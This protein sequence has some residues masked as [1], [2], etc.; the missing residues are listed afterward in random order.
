MV[1]RLLAPTTFGTLPFESDRVYIFGAGPMQPPVSSLAV[2]VLCFASILTD[3]FVCSAQVFSL[4]ASGASFANAS[5]LDA[6]QASAMDQNI[7]LIDTQAR[8]PLESQAGSLSKLDLKAPGKARHEY[9][10]GYQLLLRKDMTGALEHLT[11][12]TSIYPSFVAAHNAL[13]SAYLGLNRNEDARGE[14]ERSI[15]LDDHLPNSYFYLGCAELALKDY[16]SAEKSIQKATTIAPLDLELL[17]ALAYGQYMNGDFAAAVSTANRVHERK[18]AGASM[19]HLYAAAALE[20][21]RDYTGAQNQ[22]NIM[23]KEDPKSPAAEQ[24]HQL[25]ARL[26]EEALHPPS[27]DDGLNITITTIPAAAPTGPVLMP[28]HVR[29]LMQDAKENRQLAE[30]EAADASPDSSSP[31]SSAESNSPSVISG[32]PAASI[33]TKNGGFLLHAGTD[34]VAVFFA[35]TDHGKPVTNLT[36]ADLKIRDDNRPP[37]AL[38]SL[39]NES[40]LPLRLGLVIDTSDSIATRFKFEQDVAASF[41]RSVVTGAN[42]LAFVVGFSNS[43]LLVQDFTGD[44]DLISHAVTQL[45]PSGG[46]ALWDA[47]DYAAGKLASRAEFEPADK[48]LVLISD[49]E[50]N[51]SSINATQAIADAQR[52]GVCIYTVSTRDLRDEAPNSLVGERAL[53]TLAELTGGAAY[54]PG[55]IHRLKG[56]LNEL[57]QVIRSRYMVS[58][59]PDSF[60]RNGQYRAIEIGAEK[61][62]HKLHVYARKGYI[63]GPQGSAHF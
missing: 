47:V 28:E 19:V 23:L 40:E 22:L 53:A 1:D 43:V 29:K 15:Q 42:D 62:G 6:I 63:A 44:R 10:K 24:A 50:D 2:L 8:S 13:G 32:Q 25:I 36:W 33:P 12:A 46:T 58:Y 48:I 21:E 49:G 39:R 30:A 56:S 60:T 61:D 55:S 7:W 59:K 11:T 52:G 35:A 45:V 37:A 26:K 34:E 3:A 57:Q 17:T 38:T 41:L 9:E 54:V 16:S 27:P 20:A 4:P 5:P 18:H 51:S 14:F 31:I